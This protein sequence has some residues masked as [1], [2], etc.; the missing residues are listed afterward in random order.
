[1]SFQHSDDL[2]LD[3]VNVKAKKPDLQLVVVAKVPQTA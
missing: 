2:L 1:M 3:A